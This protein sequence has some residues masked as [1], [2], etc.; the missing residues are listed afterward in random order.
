[1]MSGVVKY[2]PDYEYLDNILSSCRI[3]RLLDF[4]FNSVE[5]K[6]HHQPNG[7]VPTFVPAS[8]RDD[9]LQ[10]DEP[11]NNIDNFIELGDNNESYAKNKKDEYNLK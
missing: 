5:N 11:S 9:S 2:I 1:M 7:F 8:F 6:N 4:P 10:S 3:G